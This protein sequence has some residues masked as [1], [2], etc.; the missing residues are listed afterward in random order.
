ML[1]PEDMSHSVYQVNTRFNSGLIS[2]S[3]IYLYMI[4]VALFRNFLCRCYL[5]DM[6]FSLKTNGLVV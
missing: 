3:L 6:L 2:G 1:V 5:S 4:M